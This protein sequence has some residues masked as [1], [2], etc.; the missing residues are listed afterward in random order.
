MITS[1][2]PSNWHLAGTG[3]ETVYEIVGLR[4]LVLRGTA[5]KKL[6]SE[7]GVPWGRKGT[8]VKTEFPCDAPLS[9]ERQLAFDN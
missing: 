1:L 8:V 4:D 3:E 2:P 7:L 9:P 6:F 5:E